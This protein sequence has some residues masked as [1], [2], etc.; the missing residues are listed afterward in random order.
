MK[1]EGV[2]IPIWFHSN[3]LTTFWKHLWVTLWVLLPPCSDSEGLV[4]CNH[5]GSIS[6]DEFLHYSRYLYHIYYI[7]IYYIKSHKP[8][9]SFRWL[10]Q[11]SW[12][13]HHFLSS[14][15]SRALMAEFINYIYGGSYPCH[16]SHPMWKVCVNFCFPSF[17]SSPLY[18]QEVVHARKL[19]KTGLLIVTI[20]SFKLIFS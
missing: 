5:T 10:P 16:I 17:L 8:C 20:L 12:G 19:I 1:V 13:W 9:F 3:L 7:Y 6:N 2:P 18:F 15:C 4:Y 11:D 14:G